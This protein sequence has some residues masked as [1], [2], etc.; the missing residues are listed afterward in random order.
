[1]TAFINYPVQVHAELDERKRVIG[2][3]VTPLSWRAR[4]RRCGARCV[5]LLRLVSQT[6]DPHLPL[7]QGLINFSAQIPIGPRRNASM[8]VFLIQNSKG[9][10]GVEIEASDDLHRVAERLRSALGVLT[11]DARLKGP[12]VQAGATLD[13]S[14]VRR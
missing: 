14:A 9:H 4:L 11:F 3:A 5:G 6:A 2:A 7:A 12:G 1:V 10:L 13:V 8:V